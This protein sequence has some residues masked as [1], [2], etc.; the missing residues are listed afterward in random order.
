MKKPWSA[1]IFNEQDFPI[2]IVRLAI[3]KGTGIDI[4]ELKEK[5]IIA[6]ANSLTDMNPGHMHLRAL[7]ERAKEG[8]HAAG[9]I[10]FEFNVPAPCDGLTEGNEGMRFVLPQR[11]LIADIV[12]T[13]VRS[14]LFDGIVMIAGCDKIIP[15]MIMAAARLDRPTIFLPGGPGAFQIR[16]S[17]SM[18]GTVNDQ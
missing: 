9:G 2:S 15:G 16:F 10:P 7:A 17:P 8:I 18:K 4:D 1:P 3:L 5:P 6:V 14:M 12:E 11:E 13:H